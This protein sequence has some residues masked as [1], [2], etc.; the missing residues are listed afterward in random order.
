[1]FNPEAKR[2]CHE[3]MFP[4]DMKKAFVLGTISLNQFEKSSYEF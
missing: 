4:E 3:E 2:I 1:M